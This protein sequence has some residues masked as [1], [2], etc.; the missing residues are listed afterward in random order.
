M[1]VITN[2]GDLWENRRVWNCKIDFIFRVK[3]YC[4]GYVE[5]SQRFFH[6]RQYNLKYGALVLKFDLRFCRMDIHID[7]GRVYREIEKIRGNHVPANQS[8]IGFRDCFVEKV[9]FHEPVVYEKILFPVSFSGVLGN[10]YKAVDGD[11][12]RFT[13]HRE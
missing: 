3:V 4:R 11:D 1:G 6:A 10:A 5:F 13:I 12:S 9:V 2:L 7:D 8:G